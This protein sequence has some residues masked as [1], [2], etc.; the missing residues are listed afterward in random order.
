MPAEIPPITSEILQDIAAH[1]AE[2]FWI[3]EPGNPALIY[4]SPAYERIW[5]RSREALYAD[6]G[7]W[8]A[9]VHPDDRSRI[10]RA[11]ETTRCHGG[12]SEEYRILR[13]DGEIRWVR[14]HVFATLDGNGL[15]H[16]VIGIAEDITRRKAMEEELR[17]SREQLRELVRRQQWDRELLRTRIAREIHDELGQSLMA[18]NVNAYWLLHQ[19]PEE[20]TRLRAKAQEMIDIIGATVKAIRRISS[21]LRPSMLDE[22]GLEEAIRWYVERFVE[23]TGIDCRLDVELGDLE[24]EGEQATAVY[25]I[26]QE[27]FTNISRHSDADGIELG[28]WVVDNCLEMEIRDNGRGM[29]R[30]EVEMSR[31][32]GLMGMRERAAALGGRL[33]IESEP[34]KGTRLRLS[35]PLEP[36]QAG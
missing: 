14:D 7:Q 11:F 12:F 15:P 6:P 35:L 13:P 1:I 25:R 21:E 8:L 29:D 34:G 36:E 18:L 22:L 33:D 26:L 30:N 23:R 10:A 9:S 28:V 27:A 2:V 32:F 4:V 31:S 3:C 16:W 5:G 19:L 20:D 17:A 24:I